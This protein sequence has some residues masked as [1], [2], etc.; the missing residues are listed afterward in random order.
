MTKSMSLLG[1][2]N[3]IGV[4]GMGWVLA[5]S[6]TVA[7]SI[8]TPLARSAIL[9]GVNPT[10][11]LFSR[12]LLTTVLLVATFAIV[13]RQRLWT[14]RR[15]MWRM[16]GIGFISGVEICCFFW[17]LAFVDASMAAMIK[18]LQPLAV[19]LLLRLGGE[20]ITRRHVARLLLAFAGLYLLIGPGGEVAPIGVWLLFASIVLYALQ[21]VFT[22][23]YLADY[24]TRTITIYLLTLMTVVVAGLWWFEGAIWRDPGGYGWLVIVIMAVVSTYFARLALY[25]AVPRIGSGQIAL[26][27]PVQMLLGVI[28]SVWLLQERLSPMQWLGGGLILVSA[29]LAARRIEKMA[30]R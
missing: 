2:E 20:S 14:D 13:D 25:A 18:S 24:D 30:Q 21:L 28:F 29:F 19:L 12:L 27:W 16:A 17:S 9:Y 1:I 23:W 11:M 3:R 15:G 8:V 4:Q 6:T 7:S 22:Q 26:L 10:A 5:L